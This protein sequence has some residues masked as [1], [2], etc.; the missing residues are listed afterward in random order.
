MLRLKQWITHLEHKASEQPGWRCKHLQTGMSQTWPKGQWDKHKDKWTQ[1]I[2][3]KIIIITPDPLLA[4]FKKNFLSECVQRCMYT[5]YFTTLSKNYFSSFREAELRASPTAVM[6]GAG[7]SPQLQL[8][9]RADE[10]TALLL[11][12]RSHKTSTSTSKT[13]F[14]PLF[15]VT[16]L[17]NQD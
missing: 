12:S 2:L 8:I 9:I 17:N 3:R 14:Y 6:M 11:V 16:L 13:N 4:Q 5:S 15:K 1:E 10:Q 7:M